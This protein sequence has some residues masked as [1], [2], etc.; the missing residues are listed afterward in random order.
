[1]GRQH[2]TVTVTGRRLLAWG[3]RPRIP[4]GAGEHYGA[5]INRA[6]DHR[7]YLETLAAE[8]LDHVR[9]FLGTYFELPGQFHIDGNTLAPEPE[10]RSLVW[11]RDGDGRHDLSRIDPAH[12]ERLSTILAA[13]A[14]HGIV[15]GLCLFCP[16]Y[17]DEQWA[18]HPL[19]ARNNRQGAGEDQERARM[20]IHPGIRRWQEQMLDAVLPV[21]S[22]AGGTYID[23]CNEPYQSSADRVIVGEHLEWQAWLAAQ[24]RRRAPQLPISCN[25]GNRAVVLDPAPAWADIA[26]VHYAVPEAAWL[27]RGCGLVVAA[28]ETGFQGQDDAIYR[29]QAWEFCLAGGALFS[30]LDYSFTVGHPDGT[31]T[32]SARTPG[33]GGA[34]LRRQ[35]AVLRRTLA[36][37]DV[38]RLR[39]YPEI[40][41]ISL[42]QG[43]RVVAL[44][45]P[46]ESALVHL[47]DWPGIPLRC[48]L[49]PGAWTATWLD[50]VAG[51]TH[52]PQTI[53]A[54]RMVTPVTPPPGVAAG[55][56]LVLELHRHG[57]PGDSSGQAQGFPPVSP[58]AGQR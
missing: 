45:V 20:L 52:P 9:L 34:P 11:C 21:A 58:L 46:D 48:C 57:S 44:G 6:F 43:L 39:S 22:A 38:L 28:D 12:L 26:C 1:M 54:T 51:H 3:G 8:G 13:A 50:P 10:D 30:H 32:I 41:D 14:N 15:V 42:P 2:L 31:A 18:V 27:N 23:L 37:F 33:W 47:V 4:I 29:R 35:L 17:S 24:V 7:S 49:A 40:L 55:T 56:D 36:R 16:C 5:L 25:P 53:I 19:R